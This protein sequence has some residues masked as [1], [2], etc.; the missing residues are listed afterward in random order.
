MIPELK[1]FTY[2][3]SF[4]CAL[5]WMQAITDS[6]LQVENAKI[7]CTILEYQH[8]KNTSLYYNGYN[9]IRC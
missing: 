1:V 9:D 3:G 5:C 4:E 8:L 7:A 2:S 6:S